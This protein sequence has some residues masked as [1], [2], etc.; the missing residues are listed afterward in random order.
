[1]PEIRILPEHIANQIAAGEVVEGP[2]SI[3]KELVENSI[4]A[5]STKIAIEISK[6]LLRIQVI[7]NGKGISNEDLKLAFKKHATSKITNIEDIYKLLT[8]GFRGE[9]LASI[10]SVSKVTCISKRAQ[11]E[12]ASKIYLENGSETLT[13]TGANNGTNI[14]VDELFF[15]TPA[16]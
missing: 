4:D 15:N 12:H 8:N 16:R 3:I 6:N 14:L 9:A 5:Q 10:A 13:Q 1:M 7:D 11:D 2:S